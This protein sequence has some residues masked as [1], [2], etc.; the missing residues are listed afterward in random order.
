MEGTEVG[1]LESERDREGTSTELYFKPSGSLWLKYFL[2]TH[3]FKPLC[4]CVWNNDVAMVIG[5][6]KG[7]SLNQ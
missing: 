5:G 7:K 4:D 2:N 6:Q 1:G 3:I